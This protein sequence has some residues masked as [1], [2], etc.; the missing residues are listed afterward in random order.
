MNVRGGVGVGS[1]GGGCGRE[2]T[3]KINLYF[4]V[5]LPLIYV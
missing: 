1:G 2:C 3:E 4:A 5:G